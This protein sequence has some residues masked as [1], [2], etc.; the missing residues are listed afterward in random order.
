MTQ[1]LNDESRKH[2]EQ[3]AGEALAQLE[4]I[5]ETARASCTMGGHW[6]PKRWQVSIR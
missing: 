2:I 1:S 6:A 3:I 4:S 5:A